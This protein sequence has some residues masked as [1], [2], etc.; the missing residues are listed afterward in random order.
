MAYGG[1]GKDQLEDQSLEGSII[2][3][4]ISDKSGGNFQTGHMSHRF[5]INGRLLWTL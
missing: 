1:E 4:W 5:H 3:K 2:L